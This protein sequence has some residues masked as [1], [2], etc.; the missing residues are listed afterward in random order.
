MHHTVVIIAPIR[1]I[2]MISESTNHSAWTYLLLLEGVLSQE[3][4]FIVVDE[5]DLFP[6]KVIGR[7]WLERKTTLGCLNPM[8]VQTILSRRNWTCSI[9]LC[10]MQVR[11]VRGIGLW[12]LDHGPTCAGCDA[13]I[14]RGPNKWSPAWESLLK[15]VFSLDR[16]GR[17][18]KFNI[19]II[20]V[21]NN[22]LHV[23]L[24]SLTD[25]SLDLAFRFFNFFSALDPTVH[26]LLRTRLKLNGLPGVGTHQL[27][28]ILLLTG[29]LYNVNRRQFGFRL[30]KLSLIH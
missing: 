29:F 7:A 27:C 8:I 23:Q 28:L 18:D 25:L 24:R 2:L 12:K 15:R 1:I 13:L 4:D 26:L 17:F 20:L 9:A 14:S 11:K 19:F 10:I 16:W 30:W 5:L 3:Y 6:L 21:A 22:F